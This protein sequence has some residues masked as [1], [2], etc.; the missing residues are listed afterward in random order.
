M[1]FP[2]ILL[3]VPGRL[4]WGA[5]TAVLRVG[6]SEFAT[7][8]HRAKQSDPFI[9]RICIALLVHG[10]AW[11]SRCFARVFHHGGPH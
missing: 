4:R 10:G 7:E 5:A 9:L 8:R 3:G 6:P 2:I 1:D 11:G